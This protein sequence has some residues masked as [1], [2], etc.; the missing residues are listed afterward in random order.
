[1]PFLARMIVFAC[2]LVPA[3]I[4]F[5]G[6]ALYGVDVSLLWISWVFVLTFVPWGVL[7]VA[8]AISF[9]PSI[10]RIDCFTFSFHSFFVIT[11]SEREV[12]RE[13]GRAR[14]RLSER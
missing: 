11:L 10:F 2:V 6:F 1:M 4:S 8:C 13:R 14:E 3:T 12:E 9:D 5:I 7:L